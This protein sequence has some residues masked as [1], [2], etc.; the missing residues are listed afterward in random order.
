M[1]SHFFC[2][3]STLQFNLFLIF[4]RF[5]VPS[6]SLK[7]IIQD[8]TVE[9]YIFFDNSTDAQPVCLLPLYDFAVLS[10]RLSSTAYL[11]HRISARQNFCFSF[12]CSPLNRVMNYTEKVFTQSKEL[13]KCALSWSRYTLPFNP[14]TGLILS[15]ESVVILIRRESV[16]IELVIFFILSVKLFKVILV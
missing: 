5:C 13:I 6:R 11:H 16:I 9:G 12:I 14:S 4:S 3:G 15:Y 7:S 10:T 8:R 2:K 1:L